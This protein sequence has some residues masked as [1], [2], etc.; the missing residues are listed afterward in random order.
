MK[1]VA[2]KRQKAGTDVSL[3]AIW[4]TG[5][6]SIRHK[7]DLTGRPQEPVNRIITATLVPQAQVT[8]AGSLRGARQT[9]EH[10]A[11]RVRR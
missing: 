2:R 1:K 5:K 6:C 10:G 9:C 11:L 3:N 8:L 7:V 4:R